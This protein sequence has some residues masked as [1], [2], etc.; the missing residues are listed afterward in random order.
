MK[1][2]KFTMDKVLELREELEKKTTKNYLTAKSILDEEYQKL[3]SLEGEMDKI[4][5]PEGPV[6]INTL[7]YKNLYKTMLKNK[8]DQQLNLIKSKEREVELIRLN[9]LEVQKEKKIIQRLKEKDYEKYLTKVKMKEI[10]EL[11]E[12]ATLRYVNKRS[13]SV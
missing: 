7:N 1:E 8:I 5:F 2:Y 6:D 4:N 13:I 11:D 10:I 9:L 12:I 3:S